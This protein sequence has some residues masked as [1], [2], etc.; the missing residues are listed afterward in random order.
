MHV[1]TSFPDFVILLS[2]IQLDRRTLS[3]YIRKSHHTLDRKPTTATTTNRRRTC[4]VNTH[5]YISAA[6]TW[7]Y[8]RRRARWP[9]LGRPWPG[10]WSSGRAWSAGPGSSRGSVRRSARPGA[11]GAG[12]CSAGPPPCRQRPPCPASSWPNARD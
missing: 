1:H 2:L 7:T 9:A 12:A 6:Y 3:L 11:S 8:E 5:P 10:A 4:R